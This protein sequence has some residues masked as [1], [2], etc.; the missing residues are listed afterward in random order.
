MGCCTRTVG[1]VHARSLGLCQ[2]GLVAVGRAVRALRRC[3]ALLRHG[4]LW[5]INVFVTICEVRWGESLARN[6][7]ESL[8]APALR[9]AGS[10]LLLM[11][12]VIAR[13][14]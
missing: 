3:F 14:L 4:K 7:S 2:D 9:A 11:A 13:K 12:A 6:T 8:F 1:V 10:V 5:S